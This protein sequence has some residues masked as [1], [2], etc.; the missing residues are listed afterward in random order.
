[1]ATGRKIPSRKAATAVKRRKP[2]AKRV[3][4]EPE[5]VNVDEIKDAVPEAAGAAARA[6]GAA[7]DAAAAAAGGGESARGEASAAAAAAGDELNALRGAVGAT[8]RIVLQAASIL[9]EE[10][11]AGIVAAKKV[12]ARF[13]DVDKLRGADPQEVMQRFR[14][15]A[16][17]VVD[18]LID[19][20]N[21][22]TNSLSGL[23]QRV[24]RISEAGVGAAAG[25][26]S[27]KLR[28]AAGAVPSLAVPQPL[29]PGESVQVP[30]TLENDGD[31]TTENFRFLCSDLVNASGDRIAGGY[32]SFLPDAL[33]I[34]PR[35]AATVTVT[36]SAPTGT[37]TGVYSGIVQATRLEQLRAVLSVRVEQ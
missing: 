35:S 21:V 5:A 19:L 34:A 25:A 3:T 26:V 27:G 6:A 8:S 23:A 22:A 29:K 36:V 1:M 30:L 32:V 2:V 17:E 13:V 16:H 9:E 37:P 11:A 14:R 7:A 4:R 31:T 28:P 12:E 15:D 24:V 20:V 33:A 18:I 10:I